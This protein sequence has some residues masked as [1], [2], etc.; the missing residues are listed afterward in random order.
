MALV[1]RTTQVRLLHVALEAMPR[2][3]RQ[4]TQHPR[5][6]EP[7]PKHINLGKMCAM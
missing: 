1:A 2:L 7:Q 3:S 4:L 6:R 5:I